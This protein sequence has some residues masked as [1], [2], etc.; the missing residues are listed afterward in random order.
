MKKAQYAVC[1]AVIICGAVAFAA[2]ASSDKR[3]QWWTIRAETLIKEKNALAPKENDLSALLGRDIA[4]AEKMAALYCSSGSP[5]LTAPGKTE[6]RTIADETA[7]AVFPVYALRYLCET[8]PSS[9]KGKET[10]SVLVP[11]VRAIF[12]AEGIDA[13]D[14]YCEKY[15][16]SRLSAGDL[17]RAAAE[18]AII[19]ITALSEKLTAEAGDF[20]LQSVKKTGA[21]EPAAEEELRKTAADS[22]CAFFARQSFKEKTAPDALSAAKSS[23]WKKCELSA[24]RSAKRLSAVSKFAGGSSDIK[25]A[26]ALENIL[27]KQDDFEKTAFRRL[28]SQ[29]C[30]LRAF[31]RASGSAVI[32]AEPDMANLFI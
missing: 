31:P 19:K 7:R 13:D 26:Q 17:S 21:L 24:R 18:C 11:M 32:P 27:R 12:T 23:V 2:S 28:S 30:D 8:Y 3:S 29:Y 1:L 5:N 9:D 20:A 14:A 4:R 16:R 10:A 6:I 25:D 15:I 22:V